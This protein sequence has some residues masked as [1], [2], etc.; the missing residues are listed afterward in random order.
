MASPW[1]KRAFTLSEMDCSRSAAKRQE[2][3]TGAQECDS[4]IDSFKKQLSPSDINSQG[5]QSRAK[6][7]PASTNTYFQ[8]ANSD[9][10]QDIDAT[11]DSV[12]SILQPRDNEIVLAAE[13]QRHIKVSALSSQPGRECALQFPETCFGMVQKIQVVSD[14]PLSLSTD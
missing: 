4:A 7:F 1:L 8:L 5:S 13:P 10:S 12:D 2:L 3:D 14:T 9:L 6:I 11:M